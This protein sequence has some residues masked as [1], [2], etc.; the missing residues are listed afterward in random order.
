MHQINPSGGAGAL[1]AM[2]DAIAL[3]N[4]IA[5]LQSKDFSKVEAIFKEYQAERLPVAKEAYETSQLFT[6]NLG[7][8]CSKECFRF[9]K[10][11]FA[12]VFHL[13]TEHAFHLRPSFHEANSLF[14]VEAVNHKAIGFEATG[15]LLTID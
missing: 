7:K 14:S 3:A 12:N 11:I 10:G 6:R 5:T 13:N 2:H 15:F 4:W 9:L 8:V 1:T